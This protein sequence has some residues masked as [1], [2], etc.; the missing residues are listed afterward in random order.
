MNIDPLDSPPPGSE[1]R[2]R[3]HPLPLYRLSPEK[4]KR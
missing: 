4:R 3:F 1:H 2:D